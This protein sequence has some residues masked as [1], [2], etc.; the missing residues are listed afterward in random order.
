MAAL[1]YLYLSLMAAMREAEGGGD[2]MSFKLGRSFE[3]QPVA[4]EEATQ[5]RHGLSA[6]E[7]HGV[8]AGDA[9]EDGEICRGGVVHSCRHRAAG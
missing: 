8:V 2:G 4:P 5:T 6:I 1:I 9:L 3:L 7:L